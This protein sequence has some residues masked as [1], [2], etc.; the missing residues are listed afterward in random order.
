ML[1]QPDP[2]EPLAGPPRKLLVAE[3]VVPLAVSLEVTLPGVGHGA[4]PAG[5]RLLAGVSPDVSEGVV[6]PLEDLVTE[7]AAVARSVLQV[8]QTP[9]LVGR[10]RAA[11][12]PRGG[13]HAKTPSPETHD[14]KM[15]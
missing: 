4:H 15:R 6:T 7:V 3:F 5:E 13:E 8:S 11:G 12:D 9:A 1:R 14:L 10:R 2:R